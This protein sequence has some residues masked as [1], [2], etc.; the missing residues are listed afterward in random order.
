ME[1]FLGIYSFIKLFSMWKAKIKCCTLLPDILESTNLWKILRMLSQMSE[2]FLGYSCQCICCCNQDYLQD[3]MKRWHIHRMLTRTS[4]IF[5]DNSW[6]LICCYDQD[7]LTLNVGY[8]PWS[9]IYISWSRYK[10]ILTKVLAIM[11]MIF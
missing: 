11:I 6:Q 4:D 5:L 3:S 9:N 7:Y 1:E 10:V 8:F 2:I